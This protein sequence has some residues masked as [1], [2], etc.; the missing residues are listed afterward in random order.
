M[1]IVPER[2]RMD[3]P[4]QSGDH[5]SRSRA[6]HSLDF[7]SAAP[8]SCSAPVI[9]A[10]TFSRLS[11]SGDLANGQIDIRK[12]EEKRF[13]RDEIRSYS[14]SDGSRRQVLLQDVGGQFI[15]ARSYD[16]Q[17]R[18]AHEITWELTEGS[19]TVERATACAVCPT[20]GAPD[21]QA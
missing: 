5:I 8:S 1:T 12:S 14:R 3:F 21:G 13:S 4:C 11:R 6:F 15:F 19:R 16:H 18:R 10:Y 9:S 7:D 20:S 2:A 17:R